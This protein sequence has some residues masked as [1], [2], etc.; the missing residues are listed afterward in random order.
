[1]SAATLSVASVLAA[2]FTFAEVSAS[3]KQINPT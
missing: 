1:M 3:V 2:E